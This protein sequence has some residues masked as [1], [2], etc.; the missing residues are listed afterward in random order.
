VA[1]QERILQGA[2]PVGFWIKV[3]TAQ[4]VTVAREG[5]RVV[6]QAPTP[7]QVFEAQ[8][9]LLRKLIGDMKAVEQSGPDGKPQQID[10]TITAGEMS[11][12]E[13]AR[14]AAT[15]LQRGA[16]DA[17]EDAPHHQPDF[18]TAY[19]ASQSPAGESPA[20]PAPEAAP[21]SENA[22]SEQPGPLQ[23]PAVGEAVRTFSTDRSVPVFEIHNN[24]PQRAGLPDLFTL[25]R[26]GEVITHGSW[27]KVLQKAQELAG[28]PL[29]FG[30][31]TAPK[32]AP[33]EN[34]V[35]QDQRP[36]APKRPAVIRRN[37]A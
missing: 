33:T 36:S 24:G 5:R 12:R 32:A 17:E 3:A 20:S 35:P 4:P 37:R 29:E 28:G 23:P 25:C 34:F 8:A 27:E 9:V 26:G 30:P 6:K 31:S 7:E 18:A 19:Q 22:T 2:D 21:K 16:D 1:T 10:S 13:L 14:R 15:L 11:P